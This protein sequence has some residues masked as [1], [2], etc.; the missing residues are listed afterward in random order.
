[1]ANG[2]VS[3]SGQWRLVKPVWR[4]CLGVLVAQLIGMGIGLVAKPI[5]HAFIDIWY[6][7]A[8]ATPIGF[9]G[10]TIW[11]AVAARGSLEQNRL[12]ILFL[13]VLC[14]LLPIFGYFTRDIWSSLP[15]AR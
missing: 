11:Q 10:G 13:A 2:Q 1:M 15:I 8:Y 7:A 4:V 6:G 14:F 3:L 5:G 9:I 12:V